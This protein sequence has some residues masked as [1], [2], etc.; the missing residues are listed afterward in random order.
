MPVNMDPSK[1]RRKPPAKEIDEGNKV[2]FK[3][4]VEAEKAG[5]KAAKNCH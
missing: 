3:T 4:A 2:M 5:F 1:K